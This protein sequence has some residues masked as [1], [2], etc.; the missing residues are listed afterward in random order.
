MHGPKT[1]MLRNEVSNRHIFFHIATQTFGRP[2]SGIYGIWADPNGRKPAKFRLTV[3]GPSR[4]T[5]NMLI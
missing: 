4:E 3:D 5:V 2:L 1:V